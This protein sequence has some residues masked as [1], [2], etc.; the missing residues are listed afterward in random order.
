MSVTITG[1]TATTTTPKA[2]QA[3]NAV[4]GIGGLDLTSGVLT[5][6][7]G[8][9]RSAVVT[10]PGATLSQIQA[11]VQSQIETDQGWTPGSSVLT[12]K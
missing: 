10:V 8:Q 4:L 5:V 11:L 9:G 3:P 7:Y 1:P 6:L 2:V 12:I